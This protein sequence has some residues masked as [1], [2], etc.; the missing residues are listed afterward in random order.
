MS[1][2]CLLTTI[3]KNLF[4]E[5]ETHYPEEEEFRV[6]HTENYIWEFGR[7]FVSIFEARL[8]KVHVT[9]Q[10]IQNTTGDIL[11]VAYKKKFKKLKLHI[12][13]ILGE[14]IFWLN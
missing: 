14:L 10:F 9:L 3:A 2:L 5:C 4:D 12:G 7:I 11:K 8:Q 1:L 13:N 6:P